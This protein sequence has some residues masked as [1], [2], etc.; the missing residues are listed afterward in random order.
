MSDGYIY[1]FDLDDSNILN[2]STHGTTCHGRMTCGSVVNS[3][4]AA[5]NG[6]SY[7]HKAG[8][9]KRSF[10]DGKRY[11]YQFVQIY[12]VFAQLPDT[13]ADNVVVPRFWLS[14]NGNSQGSINPSGLGHAN[15]SH[16]NER[17]AY[18]QNNFGGGQGWTQIW[19]KKDETNGHRWF[20]SHKSS[21]DEAL[22]WT[23]LDSDMKNL[24]T[25]GTVLGTNDS[26]G[27][28]HVTYGLSSIAYQDLSKPQ[29]GWEASN[30]DN[31]GYGGRLRWDSSYAGGNMPST[32]QNGSNNHYFFDGSTGKDV[33]Y[34]ANWSSSSKGVYK[35]DLSTA[36]GQLVV[37]SADHAAYRGNYFISF[38][39]PSQSVIN[40][41]TYTLKP[42]LKVRV[43]GIR[44]DRS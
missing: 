41:R 30:F 25:N 5:F 13:I 15:N 22:I 20:I 10:V 35:L 14:G 7:L 31:P 37:G 3:P 33:F 42:G 40:S 32:F 26:S 11:F 34:I 12:G 39:T 1:F 28:N 29:L 6:T 17:Y 43:T 38:S 23:W 44:E 24:T 21:S 9:V 4:L 27:G 18:N 16:Y 2:P 8:D 19:I 36:A